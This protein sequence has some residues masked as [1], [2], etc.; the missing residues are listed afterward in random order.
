[1]PIVPDD[2]AQCEAALNGGE[3]ST[4]IIVTIG[5]ASVGDRDLWRPAA[6]RLGAQILF[7]K[8]A[9]QPGKPCWHARFPDGRLLLGLPGNPASAFVCAH[10]FLK[11]LLFALTGRDPADA[12]VPAFGI[13]D[14]ELAANG[15]RE[16]YLRAA[17]MNG[18]DGRLVVRADPRQDSNLFTPLAA[19]NALIRRM[20]NEPAAKKG[21]L[22]ELLAI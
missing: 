5:G 17:V 18:A 7:D 20:A 19:A 4:D 13:L 8:V 15:S 6:L 1:M 3:N 11:P 10:L 22:V 12:M 14:G 16:T 21:D 2:P 9:V